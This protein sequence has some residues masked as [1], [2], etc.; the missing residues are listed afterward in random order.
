MARKTKENRLVVADAGW[1]K[2]IPEWILE[3]IKSF[4]LVNEHDS[5]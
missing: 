4:P 2:T 3:E 1:A 5:R